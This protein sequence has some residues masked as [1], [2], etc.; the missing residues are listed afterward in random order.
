MPPASATRWDF[1]HGVYEH[2]GGSRR[3][4]LEDPATGPGTFDCVDRRPDFTVP[5]AFPTTAQERTD[6]PVGAT[7]IDAAVLVV[8]C[9]SLAPGTTI[10]PQLWDVTAGASVSPTAAAC[11]AGDADYTGANQHQEIPVAIVPGHKYRLRGIVALN[12]GTIGE[13]FLIGRLEIP[14]PAA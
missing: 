7:L 2:L 6:D 8:D 12:S 14:P 10:T 3:V 13:T 11:S 9:R 4:A 1:F 5:D